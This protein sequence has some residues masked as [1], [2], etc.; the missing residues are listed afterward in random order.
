MCKCRGLSRGSKGIEEIDVRKGVV[1]DHG[2]RKGFSWLRSTLS[3]QARWTG[4]GE[5]SI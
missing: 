1:Y 3:I 2:V 4:V 5:T